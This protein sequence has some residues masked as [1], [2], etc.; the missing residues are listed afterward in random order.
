[1]AQFYSSGWL[2]FLLTFTDALIRDPGSLAKTR[3]EHPHAILGERR[4]RLGEKQ[5]LLTC[6]APFGQFLFTRS[7]TVEVVQ[8]VAQAI[9]AEGYASF[10]EP[11]PRTVITPCVRSK[12]PSRSPHNSDTRMPVS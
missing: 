12:S 8:E 9:V 7:V 4:A 2:T 5:V 3:E 11:F 1:M 6:A 10:L